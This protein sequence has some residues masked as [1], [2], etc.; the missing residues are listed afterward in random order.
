MKTKQS[1]TENKLFPRPWKPNH[2]EKYEG[3]PNNIIVRSSW[4][5]RFLNWCDNNHHIISYSSEEIVIPYL[6]P[7]DNKY[8]RY[9]PD[10]K[11]RLDTG[12]IYIVEIKPFY[13]CHKPTSKNKKRYLLEAQTYMINSSKWKYAEEFCKKRGWKFKII[14]EYELGLKTNNAK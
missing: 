7:I 1:K 12:Q 9:F 3:D 14:T 13:Q 8:H 10:A 4:E 6:S 11:I 2:P 5:V